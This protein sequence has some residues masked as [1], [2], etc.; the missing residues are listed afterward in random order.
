MKKLQPLPKVS[1]KRTIFVMTPVLMLSLG[2]ILHFT[3]EF[4]ILQK[5]GLPYFFIIF[6]M[7]GVPIGSLFALKV[8]H[9][10]DSIIVFLSQ[11]ILF[12]FFLISLMIFLQPIFTPFGLFGAGFCIG[13]SG[14]PNAIN[15][16]SAVPINAD[17]KYGGRF[18]GRGMAIS[19][20]FVI[21]YAARG[22]LF[23]II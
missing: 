20:I 8:L 3:F 4:S 18:F 14:G 22:F 11:M 2:N 19:S 17:P 16:I 1:A 15:S 23:G 12:V 7:I 9:K 21:I 10:W 13:I 6:H 5:V